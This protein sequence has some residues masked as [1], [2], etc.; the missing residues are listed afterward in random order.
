MD[1]GYVIHE[2]QLVQPVPS[3]SYAL[4]TEVERWIPSRQ[5]QW[6]RVIRIFDEAILAGIPVAPY[7]L[8]FC[9]PTKRSDRIIC[10]VLID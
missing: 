3:I 6:L 5:R 1:V 9:H 2:N 8:Y 4:V 10:A 7:I